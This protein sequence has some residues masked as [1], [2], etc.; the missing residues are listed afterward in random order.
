MD[1]NTLQGQ[2]D[3]S[4]EVMITVEEFEEPLELHLHDTEIAE[5]TITLDLSDGTLTVGIDNV[6]GYWV[7]K[8]SLEHY[9]LE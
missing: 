2:L 1:A 4:G 8:H 6:T 5:D 3:E 9:G 7:H